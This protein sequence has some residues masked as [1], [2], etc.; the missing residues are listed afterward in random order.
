M[1][2]KNKSSA[3]FSQKRLNQRFRRQKW[4]IVLVQVS[5]G[6][7]REHRTVVLNQG[8]AKALGAIGVYTVTKKHNLGL[9]VM[10]H[11][12]SVWVS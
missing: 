8:T 3:K 11:C 12:A 10:K 5:G 9:G 4:M 7:G 2:H 1:C 6:H